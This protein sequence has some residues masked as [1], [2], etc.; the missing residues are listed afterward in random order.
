MFGYGS[1]GT[2]TNAGAITGTSANGV[3]V[4]FSDQGGIQDNTLINSGRIV[5]NSGTAAQ[6]GDGNDLL[7]LL[8]G[9]T[10]RRPGS[11]AEAAANTLELAKGPS[12]WNDRRNRHQLHRLR[13]CHSGQRRELEGYR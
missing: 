2:V 7:K 6:F 3:G 5:G 8:P 1:A 13:H 9:A 4:V 12:T 10:L 11:M